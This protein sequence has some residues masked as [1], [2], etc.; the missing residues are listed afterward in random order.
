MNAL[1]IASPSVL[2]LMLLTENRAGKIHPFPSEI[3]DH[4]TTLIYLIKR[5]G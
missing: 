3:P 2:S 5:F 1:S 4:V